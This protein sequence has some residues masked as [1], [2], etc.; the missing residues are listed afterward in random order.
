[1]QEE[2]EKIE[3]DDVEKGS[4]SNLDAD[5][6][7]R[8]LS[9][10]AVANSEGSHVSPDDE[11]N[12]CAVAMFDFQCTRENELSLE[13]G[14]LVWVYHSLGQGWLLAEDSR[15]NRL[16][17]VPEE[18]VKRIGF[19]MRSSVDRLHTSSVKSQSHGLNREDF[20]IP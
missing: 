1:M 6:V 19:T 12:D 10:E 8:R 14:Q 17:L 7:E 20:P 11:T 4:E 3:D 9:W 2:V 18:F 13:Q 16:G 15:T 5:P